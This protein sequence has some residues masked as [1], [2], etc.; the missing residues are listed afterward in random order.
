VP[1]L[2]AVIG[3]VIVLLVTAFFW[4]MAMRQA[5]VWPW[6]FGGRWEAIPIILFVGFEFFVLAAVVVL[7]P[8]VVLASTVQT[9]VRWW[10][11]WL[12]AVYGW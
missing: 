6:L 4:G 3:G 8:Y 7:V 2:G 10:Q 9:V 5:G 11:R 1:S 12:S